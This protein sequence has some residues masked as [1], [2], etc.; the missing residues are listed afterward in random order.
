[1]FYKMVEM[2]IG[3]N[4]LNV[5][6]RMYTHTKY[7][8]KVDGFVSRPFTSCVGVKQG[9]PLSPL[10]FNMYLSDLPAIFDTTC[11]PVVVNSLTTNCL[12][13]ADDLVLLSE[14]PEGL[15]HCIERLGN[16]CT[17]WGLKINLSKTKIVIFNKGGMKISKF[18]FLLY[19]NHS[20]GPYS[21]A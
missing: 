16:Y 14:S 9:C 20:R 2:G 6:Q 3:G 19:N 4:L 13:F 18:K 21:S 5:L 17:R 12:L 15:Q 8:V 11:F 7:A 1:M 10:L